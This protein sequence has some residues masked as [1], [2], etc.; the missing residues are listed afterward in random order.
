[1]AHGY[2]ALN[3]GTYYSYFVPAA[4]RYNL[5]CYQV[6]GSNIYGNANATA[7]TTARQAVDNGDL[8]IACMGKGLWTRSG[9]FVLVYGI[10]GN[11]VY[12]N[13]PASTKMARTH[14]NYLVFKTQVKYYWIIKKPSWATKEDEIDMTK[15]EVREFIKAEVASQ[16]GLIQD[17]QHKADTAPE[18]KWS[19][20][21]GHWQRAIEKDL[22]DGTMPER[23]AKRDEVIAWLGRL[24]LI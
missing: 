7:H 6:N 4:K 2:K 8:V 17:A 22:T 23:A 24:G 5:T 15:D 1:M 19:K 9:H 20:L 3:Q 12:I 10:E 18:P 21:E 13:D 16:M 14:G 11:M